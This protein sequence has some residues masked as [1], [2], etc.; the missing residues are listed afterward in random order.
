MFESHSVNF[1]LFI[2]SKTSSSVSRNQCLK[3]FWCWVT[4]RA[5]CSSCISLQCWNKDQGLNVWFW[6]AGL[7]P[8]WSWRAHTSSLCHQHMLSMSVKHWQT[9]TQHYQ[10][11]CNNQEFRDDTWK[12][13]YFGPS[14]LTGE[15]PVTTKQEPWAHRFTFY[16]HAVHPPFNSCCVKQSS[17]KNKN[18]QTRKTT[19]KM[20]GLFVLHDLI[21]CPWIK[22]FTVIT[23]T[24]TENIMSR[25]ASFYNSCLS[26]AA[27]VPQL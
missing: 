5:R 21:A 7:C 25:A 15:L 24:I 17:K 12:I 18:K 19:C 26:L 9:Q 4:E 6:S 16:P 11:T 2:P 13:L 20:H 8:W 27:S 22:P 14:A 10:G 3:S 23:R 1:R